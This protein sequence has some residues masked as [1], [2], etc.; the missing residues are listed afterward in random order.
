M[1]YR[2]QIHPLL[3]CTL[4]TVT[5]IEE[6]RGRTTFSTKM[7]TMQHSDY[8][9]GELAEVLGFLQQEIVSTTP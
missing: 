9:S 4:V 1:R 5:S 7:Y 2:I 6:W 3:D 8:G